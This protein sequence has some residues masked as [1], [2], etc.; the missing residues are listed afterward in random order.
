MSNQTPLSELID[1]SKEAHKDKFGNPLYSYEK[2]KY[3]YQ[4]GDQWEIFCILHDKPFHQN[5]R[6]HI[7][8]QTGCKECSAEKK[9]N[10]SLK[11]R[12]EIFIKRAQAIHI[13]KVDG[14]PLYS[15]SKVNYVSNQKDVLINCPIHGDF[16]KTP[17][18]H[19][20]KKNPQGCQKCSNRN[21]R[22]KEEFILDAQKKHLDCNGKAIYNYSNINYVNT[23]KHVLIYCEKHNKS[24]SQ[25]PIKHLS[26][27]KCPDCAKE[28][29]AKKQT[30]TRD[31]FITAAK[32]IHVDKDGNPKYDYSEVKYLNNHTNITI[33]CLHHGPF[34]QSP[35]SHKD[36]RS[37]CKNCR[38]SKGEQIIANFLIEKKIKFECEFKFKDCV[39]KKPLPF[40]FKIEWQGQH[41]L[42][43]YQ[44]ALHFKPVSYTKNDE[45]SES[46]FQDIQAR[47][48]IKKDY[49]VKKRM[50]LIEFTYRQEFNEILIELEKRFG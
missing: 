21:I 6:K 22:T 31:E 19:T 7:S 35:S 14:K 8:G 24:F 50:E 49:A 11:E 16:N 39:Y 42:I 36:N 38:A 45:L 2:I 43:E 44:G 5:F 10:K 1:R 41:I 47:D 34:S 32:K 27:Q 17:A 26:G 23:I 9:A 33:I 13:N 25:T 15:Y 40:D 3:T 4:N 28:I 18:N 46:R 30:L 29:V 37:G 12:T 48:K 20:H